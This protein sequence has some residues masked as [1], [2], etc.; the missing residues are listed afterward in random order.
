MENKIT[1]IQLPN[2]PLNSWLTYLSFGLSECSYARV[3]LVFHLWCHCLHSISFGLLLQ[4]KCISRPASIVAVRLQT[5]GA[6]F[7]FLN[8]TDLA[9]YISTAMIG[10]FTGPITSIVV[11]I[12]T[13]LFGTQQH[14][15]SVRIDMNMDKENAWA[16]NAIETLLSSGV[17]F[18]SLALSWL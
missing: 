17:P 3:A 16:W 15:F 10:A 2:S 18:V 11:S 5:S 9:L 4:G 7:L 14:S 12:T 1:Y 6:S 8:K 13:E